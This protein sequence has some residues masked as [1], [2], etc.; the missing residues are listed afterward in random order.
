[1]QSSCSAGLRG[2]AWC[3]APAI[4]LYIVAWRSLPRAR[5]SECLCFSTIWCFT[6]VECVFS[7]LAKSLNHG[8]QE[9]CG[10]VPVAILDSLT[11]KLLLYTFKTYSELSYNILNPL[12]MCPYP[13]SPYLEQSLGQTLLYR[14]LSCPKALFFLFNFSQ[15]IHSIPSYIFFTC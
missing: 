12:M 9:V 15:K 7:L 1:V 2:R 5:G 13:S 11:P 14:I 8:G 3:A 6:S 10:C 4:F